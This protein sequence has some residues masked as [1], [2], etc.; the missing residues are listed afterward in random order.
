[1]RPRILHRAAALSLLGAALLSACS[2]R[3]PTASTATPTAPSAGP[4]LTI[5]GG[6]LD[7]LDGGST[8]SCGLT[9]GGQ[10]WCWGRNA[11][12]Q[13]GDSSAAP[14]STPVQVF[15]QAGVTF[16]KVTAGGA[17]SCGIT[18]AG[19]A[20]C[21]GSNSDGR[22]GDSTTNPGLAPVAVKPLGGG[23]AFTSISAGNE[24]TCGLN[25]SGQGYC[26]GYNGNGRLGN[27]A[28][29]FRKSPTAVQHPSGV[30]FASISA[31]STHTCALDTTGQAWCWGYGGDG[32]LGWGS[33]LGDSVPRA[34][35]HPSGV[36]FT[37]LV[38][39]VSHTCALTSGG[40]A[41]CWGRNEN[42]QLGNN[43]TTESNTPVAVQQPSGVTF[44]S[45]T[46]GG[47]HTCARTSAG[48]AYCWGRNTEGQIG[49]GSNTRR[50]TPVAVSHPSGVT[51]DVVSAGSNSTCAIATNDEVWCWGRNDF[52]QLGDGTT[53]NRNT[54][55]ALMDGAPDVIGT[56]PAHNATAVPPGDNVVI[57]FDEAV[58]VS[59]SSFT[60]TCTG[61]A[62][63]FSVSGSGTSVV[64][65]D[66]TNL[67]PPLDTCTVTVVAAQVSDVDTADPADNPS[68]DYEFSFTV[69]SEFGG[70][71]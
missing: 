56:T 12:G 68:A 41:Y 40:Q 3:V 71:P 51:F 26:W 64:T 32:A 30:T 2:D 53:T 47:S 11:M 17:H 19:Q 15:Q 44:V 39:E 46:T 58:T 7:Q 50:L 36:T 52:H 29:A 10:A 28:K 70:D 67:L 31:G 23:V 1:M 54:P 27:N 66:P 22:L 37:Q 63:A 18:S 14:S 61:G 24:H 34:V 20:W 9:T 4:S 38:T 59:G 8:H 65:L 49:D 5:I 57:T 16:V 21:W 42:G 13:L 60:F 45:L 55:G 43:T 6:G 35:T 48:Q 25:S 69:A 33:T 62:Q